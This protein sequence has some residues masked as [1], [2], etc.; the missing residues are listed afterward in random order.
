MN[1]YAD[2]PHTCSCVSSVRGKKCILQKV[3]WGIQEDIIVAWKYVDNGLKYSPPYMLRLLNNFID[4]QAN[5]L[6]HSCFIVRNDRRRFFDSI[7]T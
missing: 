4:N 5:R 7:R 2:R 3:P 1:S 6:S